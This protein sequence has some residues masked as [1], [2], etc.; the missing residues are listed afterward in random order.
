[1][2]LKKNKTCKCIPIENI[3]INLHFLFLF[4]EIIEFLL[5]IWN[6]LKSNK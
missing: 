2:Y 3:S 6:N 1:M 5:W 4:V